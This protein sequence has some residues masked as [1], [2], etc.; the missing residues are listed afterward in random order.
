MSFVVLRE[1]P[2]ERRDALCRQ[3]FNEI[4]RD[5]FPN[6]DEAE[7]PDTWLPLMSDDVPVGQP[8]VHMVLARDS[9]EQI[10]GGIIFESYRESACWL[11][12][13]IAV[14]PDA[15]HRGIG[16][17]LIMK[18]VDTISR[19]TEDV[20]MFAEAEIPTRLPIPAEREWGWKR[21]A[22]LTSFGFSRILINYVQPAL[23]PEKHAIDN[24]YLLLYAGERGEDVI[25][26]VRLIAFLKEFYAALHQPSSPYL[27]EM[28]DA[29]ATRT[30]LETQ[31]LPTSASDPK[32]II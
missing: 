2:A 8:L 1:E 30:I 18:T 17:S 19:Q 11:A 15:R 13:Y 7:G 23:S 12:T 29:L 25:S 3:F 24:L 4:Y 6:P 26:S 14:R 27:S 32:Y 21:L 9:G 16:E 22:I 5:V 31:S 28:C 20:I 10:L